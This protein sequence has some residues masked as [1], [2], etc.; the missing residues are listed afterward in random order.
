MT[1]LTGQNETVPGMHYNSNI[2]SGGNTT[3]GVLKPATYVKVVE[4]A[5]L[6]HLDIEKIK[7][8]TETYLAEGGDGNISLSSTASEPSD[9]KGVRG[10]SNPK[11]QK[12]VL[13]SSQGFNLCL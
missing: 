12:R 11:Y 6:N 1:P 10:V 3:H 2:S 8:A 13:P 7:L 9:K 5:T 4:L